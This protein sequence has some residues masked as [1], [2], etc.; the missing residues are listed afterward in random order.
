M[1]SD[2]VWHDVSSVRGM[3]PVREMSLP[4]VVEDELFQFGLAVADHR[5]LVIPCKGFDANLA[6]VVPDPCWPP[7]AVESGPLGR[8]F[9]L[10]RMPSSWVFPHLLV[11]VHPF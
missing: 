8:V 4:K 11:M 7:S 10:S 9:A 3:W 2:D 6:D 1:T 5:D